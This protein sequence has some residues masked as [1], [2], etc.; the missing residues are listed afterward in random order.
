MTLTRSERMIIFLTML[1]FF[2]IVNHLFVSLIGTF[3]RPR[4]HH[5]KS[6][7]PAGPPALPSRP[8]F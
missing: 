7:N 2:L 5:K 4:L 3:V 1:F 8:F 6:A